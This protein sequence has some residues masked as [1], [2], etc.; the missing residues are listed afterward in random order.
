MHVYDLQNGL[1]LKNIYPYIK[2]QEIWFWYAKEN[3]VLPHFFLYLLKLEIEVK[4]SF[5]F[6]WDGLLLKPTLVKR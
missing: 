3:V 2:F 1:K 6:F 4:S 5:S